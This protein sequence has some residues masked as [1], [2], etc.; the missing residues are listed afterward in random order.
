MP[1]GLILLQDDRKMYFFTESTVLLFTI[2][3]RCGIVLKYK[4]TEYKY[5]SEEMKQ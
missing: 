4:F 3:A 5:K 1:Q 2:Q